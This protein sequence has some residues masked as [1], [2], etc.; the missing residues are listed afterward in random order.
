MQSLF[1]KATAYVVRNRHHRTWMKVVTCLACIVVFCTTYALIL[2]AITLENKTTYCGYEE[3]EH[4]DSCYTQELICGYEAGEGAYTHSADCYDSEGNLLCDEEESEGHVHTDACYNER[5]LT[6]GQEAHTHQPECYINPDPDVETTGDE[7]TTPPENPDTEVEETEADTDE[8]TSTLAVDENGF[9][10]L[11]LTDTT[12]V[13]EFYLWLW[14]YMGDQENHGDAVEVKLLPKWIDETIKWD[15]P[16]ISDARHFGNI[17]TLNIGDE[18]YFTDMDS[19]IS[20]YQVAEVDILQPT[21][22]EEMTSGDYDLTL[23]TCTYGG[24]SR[25]TVRCEQIQ[26]N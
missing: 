2:P 14:A 24:K 7:K 17:Y 12:S 15:G 20:S 16:G 13:N 22:V 10:T 21:D 18:L 19:V 25:V 6:C 4:D 23:F 11:N 5:K 9:K 26:E 3:H 1:S 8:Q